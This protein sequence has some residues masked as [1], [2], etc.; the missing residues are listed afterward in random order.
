MLLALVDQHADRLDAAV[1]ELGGWVDHLRQVGIRG[2]LAEHTDDDDFAQPP[3][4]RSADT[5]IPTGT[6]HQPAPGESG[7]AAPRKQS[8]E[9]R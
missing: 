9:K 2:F 4:H 6:G 3:G 7:A 1:D 8:D 5:A